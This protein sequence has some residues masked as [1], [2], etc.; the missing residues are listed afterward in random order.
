MWLWWGKPNELSLAQ[1]SVAE[2]LD[3]TTDGQALRFLRLT[4]LI[5]SDVSFFRPGQVDAID[6]EFHEN[7]L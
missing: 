2:E 6:K 3:M 4:N 5:L 1:A 7:T